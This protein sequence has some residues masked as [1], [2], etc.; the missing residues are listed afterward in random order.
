[1]LKLY[2]QSTQQIKSYPRNDDEPIIGLDAD[3]LVLEQVNT[4]PPEYNPE[5]QTINSDYIVDTVNLEYRQEWVVT[6]LPPQP[7]W[8][9]FNSQ[10]LTDPEFNQVYNT[11]NS[12]APVVCASLPAALTQVSNGQLSMFNIVWNQ[13]M[14][15]GNAT[16]EMRVK[17]GNWATDNNLPIDFVSIISG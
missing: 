4:L 7:N 10:M 16:T 3:Y 14:Q 17:W 2:S 15:L 13:I 11:A 8:D 9:M 1:M 6:D 12:I 5:T